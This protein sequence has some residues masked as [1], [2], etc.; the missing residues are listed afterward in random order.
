MEA[1]A[2]L[3]S[4][5][6]QV[7][8]VARAAN[9]SLWGL[10]GMEDPFA[11]RLVHV[12]IGAMLKMVDDRIDDGLWR[13]VPGMHALFLLLG[14]ALTVSEMTSHIGVSVMMFAFVIATWETGGLDHRSFWIASAAV[15]ASHAIMLWHNQWVLLD[16]HMTMCLMGT[17]YS[18]IITTRIND[19]VDERLGFVA[20][21]F[22]RLAVG[23]FIA[24]CRQFVPQEYLGHHDFLANFTIGYFVGILLSFPEVIVSA[25]LW[26]LRSEPAQKRKG[27]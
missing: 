23:V 20:K 16:F 15:A 11:G 2:V 27:A 12:L 14:V 5:T 4:V 22:Y 1:L 19:V 18:G 13:W 6:Q 3:H 10:A 7:E 17:A 9:G 21:A 24:N 8:D 26:H 25:V